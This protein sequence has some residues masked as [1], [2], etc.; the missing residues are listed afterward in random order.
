MQK[1]A[2]PFVSVIIPILNEEEYVET[3]IT[4]IMLGYPTDRMEV[5]IVDGGSRDESVAIVKRLMDSYP[6]IRL[7]R[8][9]KRIQSAAMNIGLRELDS[10]SEL[11]IRADA[12]AV[13]P[14]D[15]IRQL[16]TTLRD[17][18]ADSVVVAMET[19]GVRCMQRGVAYAQNSAIGTGFSAHRWG[20]SSSGWVDHGHHAC[21]TRGILEKVGGY[22]EE[23]TH[24]E[25]A[26]LDYRIIQAGG[27]IFLN[28]ELRLKYYPRSR[29]RDLVRQYFLYGKGRCMTI[30]KHRIPSRLRQKLPPLWVIAEAHL[31]V[32]GV[33][34]PIFFVP[35]ICYFASV[36]LY[37]F[38]VSFA[39]KDVCALAAIPALIVM[40]NAWGTGYLTQ[41][42]LELYPR[43]KLPKL[44]KT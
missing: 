7:F 37:A 14:Q 31:I 26:E 6:Q 29:L 24:N 15:Y 21:F 22:D 32:L 43:R 36:V 9:E 44:E 20:G 4:S 34:H 23:F 5:L 35:I 19:I 11:V 33:I 10:L 16:V 42:I 13:Y 28:A 18:E 41:Y 25:D 40:H 3:C 39:R 8:N 17:K 1:E 2:Y 12:H 38:Y 30:M 27:R